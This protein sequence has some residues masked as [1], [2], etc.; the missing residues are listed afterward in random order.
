MVKSKFYCD[1]CGKEVI[2][3]DCLH[4]V[5]LPYRYHYKNTLRTA[6]GHIYGDGLPTTTEMGTKNYDFCDN[7]FN[8]FGEIMWMCDESDNLWFN[9]F[10][11][12]SIAYT[13]K[14]IIDKENE[15]VD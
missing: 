5:P 12:P 2:D 15:N 10:L 14:H 7:C 8:S 1:C 9:N 6:H 13:A 4:T 11:F 3:K